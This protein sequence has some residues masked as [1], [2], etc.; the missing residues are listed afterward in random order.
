MKKVADKPGRVFLTFLTILFVSL[1]SLQIMLLLNPLTSSGQSLAS[2]DDQP[3]LNPTATIASQ[4]VA[5]ITPIVAVEPTKNVTPALTATSSN[6]D[7]RV[8]YI[9]RGLNCPLISQISALVLEQE[10]GLSVDTIEYETVEELFATLAS[11]NKTERIDL[12]F[13]FLDPTDRPYISK[14]FA[15]IKVLGHNYL[16]YESNKLLIMAN[17][18]IVAPLKKEMPC[19]YGF[20]QKLKFKASD[21]KQAQD[22]ATW[23]QNNRAAVRNWTSCNAN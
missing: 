11:T 10:F 13:C 8:G 19:V 3:N 2:L 5:T 1:I 9:D 12:T 6:L 20:F 18:A 16:Q 21:F 22:A 23:I 4:L 15:F 7:L 17:A 14:S